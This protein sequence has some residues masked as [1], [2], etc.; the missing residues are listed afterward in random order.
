MSQRACLH[1][2]LWSVSRLAGLPEIGDTELEGWKLQAAPAGKPLQE[3]VYRLIERPC[4]GHLKR[5]WL[6]KHRTDSWSGSP[7][8]GA[9]RLKSTTCRVRAKSR[10]VGIRVGAHAMSVEQ[11][12]ADRTACSHAEGCARTVGVTELGWRPYKSA[13]AAV[14]RARATQIHGAAETVLGQQGGSESGVLPGERG[15]R[16]VREAN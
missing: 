7:G 4:C 8:A 6:R 16:V 9:V 15:Q 11:V 5:R 2:R 12:V 13:A 14:A 3:R 1:R 10:V